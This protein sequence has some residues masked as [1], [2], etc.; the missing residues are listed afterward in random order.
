MINPPAPDE[1]AIQPVEL[2]KP[3]PRA[4]EQRLRATV[5]A[6]GPRLAPLLL[7]RGIGREVPD[8]Q[9]ARQVRRAF[10]RLGATYVKLGQVVASA[11]GVFGPEVSDEFRSLLDAGRPVRFDRVQHVIEADLGR[12]LGD[13]FSSFD[14]EPI[15]RASIAVVHRATT[16]D[17]RDVAV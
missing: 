3:R 4:L 8:A 17:G 7:R 14:P 2:R 10:Q 11:P 12:S 13:A 9:F 16:R 5:H 15:G 1:L 6:F